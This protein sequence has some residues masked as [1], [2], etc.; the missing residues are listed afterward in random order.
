MLI[1]LLIAAQVA[2]LSLPDQLNIP[3]GHSTV[4]CP[5]LEAAKTMV[6]RH[7]RVKPAPNNNV[8][9][10]DQFFAGIKA[11]GC[12]Q[13]SPS[14]KGEV[15]IQSVVSRTKLSLADGEE[16]VIVYQ[17]I[18]KVDGSPLIG[19]VDE[20]S[21]N[22]YARTKLA[23][24][25]IGRTSDGWL[26]ARNNDG[27]TMIFYRCG[28][29]AQAKAVV[30]KLSGMKNSPPKNFTASLQK[31]ATAQQCRPA[32]DR[33]YVTQILGAAGNACGEECYVDLTALEAIDRSGMRVGLIFDAS[34]M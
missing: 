24:W 22:G 11:T 10:T 18:N 17:G 16:R 12:S 7:Y 33:Y 31:Q 14:R 13:D 2:T 19:I 27:G 28:T 8:I 29:P 6:T 15:I 5:T 23:E 26:D 32:S 20:D 30:E 21:N 3:D 9:D 34:L 1:S 25:M 4:I